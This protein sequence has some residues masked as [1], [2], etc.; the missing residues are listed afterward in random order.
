MPLGAID[1]TA[2]CN[3]ATVRRA[4]RH[5]VFNIVEAL[6]KRMALEGLQ[7]LGFPRRRVENVPT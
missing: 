4:I 3:P 1:L 5:V 7:S 2:G 6:D